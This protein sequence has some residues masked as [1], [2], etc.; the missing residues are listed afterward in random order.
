MEKKTGWII[1]GVTAAL[2]GCPGICLLIY[3][4]LTAMGK[5]TYEISGFKGPT[6]G[7]TP[8]WVGVVTLVFGLFM[9][10]IPVIIGLY[11]QFRGKE[12]AGVV[13]AKEEEIPPSF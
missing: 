9:F 2:C 6:T 10:A 7:Q 3:G 4:V 5:G 11:T 1:T 13:A 12:P 8:P